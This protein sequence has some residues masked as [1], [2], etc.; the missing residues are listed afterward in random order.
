MILEEVGK[1]VVK[2]D[3]R[4]EISGDLEPEDTLIPFR[5]IRIGGVLYKSILRS[6]WLCIGV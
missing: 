5:D 3:G 6:R 2:K 1:L 4:L